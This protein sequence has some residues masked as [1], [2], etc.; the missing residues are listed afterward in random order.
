MRRKLTLYLSSFKANH[1]VYFSL[2]SSSS[3][4]F[5]SSILTNFF[6]FLFNLV[7]ARNLTVESYGI[8]QT[9]L[10]L[11]NMAAILTV[12]VTLQLT[13]QLAKYSSQGKHR[14]SSA[15][16]NK[17]VFF[18]VVVGSAIIAL[19][20]LANNILPLSIGLVTSEN[21]LIVIL[22]SILG[23]IIAIQRAL[24]RANLLF[25]ALA[26]NS[27]LQ[28]A[29]KLFLSILFLLSG[30]KLYGVIISLFISS[31]MTIVYSLWQLRERLFFNLFEKINFN[32]KAFTKESLST[33]IGFLGLTSLT[34]MDL[35]LAQYYLPGLAGYYAGLTL[36]G[37]GILLTVA[38]IATVLFP[39]II[40][41]KHSTDGKKLFRIAL[42]VTFILSFSVYFIYRLVPEEI[43][44]LALSK[45]YLTI[46]TLLPYYGFTFLLFSLSHIIVN[47]FIALDEFTPGYVASLT[48]I[49]QIIGI[50]YFHNSLYD[51]IIVSLF[52]NIILAGYLIGFTL[53]KLHTITKKYYDSKL[54][55]PSSI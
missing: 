34:S 29:S 27:N 46:V 33:M 30:F 5:A 49:L 1:P 26:I 23:Y 42:L 21:L 45:S 37:K 10:N 3:I 47:G 17:S 14:S 20:I 11:F 18:V 7:T 39:L 51:I 40:N 13:K 36:F 2:L 19:F 15:L 38:P 8:L 55:S 6:N 28:Y 25:I 24:M 12:L 52:S 41:A 44:K 22:L 35:I 54:L 4:I 32:V 9:M 31:I 43:V 48:A 50:F 16:V 53:L